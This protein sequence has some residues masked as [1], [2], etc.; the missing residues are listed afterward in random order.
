MYRYLLFYYND[1]YPSGGMDDCVLKTN[2]FDDLEQFI[3][4]EYEDDY[5]QGTIHYYDAVK[6]RIVFAK[7][8]KYK[9]EDYFIRW[10]FTGWKEN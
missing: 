6:D 4:K 7:M 10:K 1:Y 9:T 5:F 8:E 2:N 3:H